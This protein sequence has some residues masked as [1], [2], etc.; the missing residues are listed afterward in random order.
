MIL[1]EQMF[2]LFVL[3]LVG[4]ICR[5][6]GMMN[7]KVS[8][9][10]SGI[11]VNIASPAFIISA[12]LNNDEIVS[13]RQ[14]LTCLLTS[15]F[16]YM[17][18]ILIAIFLPRIIKAKKSHY[19]T[20]RVMT[21]F[22]NIGFMGF[23]IVSATFQFPFNLLIYTY[24]I[25]AMQY[26][27]E[28]ESEGGFSWKLVINAGVI[29]VFV[30]VVCYL[31]HIH[32]PGPVESVITGLSGLTVPMSMMVIGYALGGMKLKDLFSDYRLM[33]F[34]VI[35]LIVI[36][37]IGVFIL[38]IFIRDTTLLG[39]C[40]IMIA[41]P[42]ASMTAMLAQYYGGDEET[43]SRGVALTT[44]LSVITIPLVGAICLR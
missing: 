19:G 39:V 1:L 16:I 20:Y 14:L 35:K 17:G 31:T 44:L 29:A 23:P 28:E 27:T 21:I 40:F 10:M 26:G 34:S 3:M 11:V 7:D 37:I 43:A 18:L 24:G 38:K 6:T 32:V 9:G 33:L 36:P 4:I 15:V 22:S 2:V 42:V 25:R 13:N 12:G 5:K 41:T 30:S 8:K